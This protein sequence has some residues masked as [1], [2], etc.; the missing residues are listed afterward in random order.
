MVP[1]FD[2]PII[3]DVRARP[4]LIQSASG[5]KDL[6]TVSDVQRHRMNNAH[7][8]CTFAS[9]LPFYWNLS[10]CKSILHEPSQVRSIHREWTGYGLKGTHAITC[11]G[12]R[13]LCQ[14]YVAS[15]QVPHTSSKRCSL[16]MQSCSPNSMD[17]TSESDTAVMV[18]CVH[19]CFQC[20]SILQL[21]T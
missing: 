21:M 20:L 4:S 8:A 6:Q 5:S 16:L 12:D 14:E 11:A 13:G 10:F 3:Y 7:T 2:R 18:S 1:W 9:E 17:R 19:I 15:N